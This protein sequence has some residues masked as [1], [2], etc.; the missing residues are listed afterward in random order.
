MVW[1]DT[2]AESLSRSMTTTDK[3]NRFVIIKN[4]FFA[5]AFAEE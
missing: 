2:R 5:Y 3:N 1:P 4:S